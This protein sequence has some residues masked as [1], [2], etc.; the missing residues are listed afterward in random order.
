MAFGWTDSHLHRFSAGPPRT[1]RDS[2]QYLCPF[3]VDEGDVGVPEQDVRLDEVL[4]DPGDRLY[5]TYDYGDDWQHV[6]ALEAVEERDPDAPRAVCTGGRRPDPQ[7]DCGGVRGYELLDAANDPAHR[8]HAGAAAELAAMYGEDIVDHLPPP[9]ALDIDEVN[10]ALAAHG[11]HSPPIELAAP[12]AELIDAVRATEG[13]RHLRQ[14]IAAADLHA[15]ADV[16]ADTA[17]QMVHP[18]TWLLH[19][20]GDD[21]I[22]LT[23]AGYLPPAHVS[24]AFTELDLADE[25]IG[26]GN[27]EDLTLPVLHLRESAQRAGLLRKFKNRLRLTARGRAGRDDPVALWRRLAERTPPHKVGEFGMHAGLVVLLLIAAGGEHADL[28]E[29]SLALVLDAVGWAGRDG[30]PLSTFLIADGAR[31]TTD[32]LHRIGAVD[33][34]GLRG[35]TPTAAGRTFARAALRTWPD[36][37]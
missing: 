15:P 26:K 2:E 20:V 9:R 4:V 21:G 5:Y 18:Y 30:A 17:A 25:W 23:A 24:A 34:R 27:R 10:A 7:E 35:L 36:A 8:D 1:G 11:F 13:A 37:K 14:L 28:A 29:G 12:L 22:K 6:L 3:D 33:G 31:E 16:D 32:V 19:H